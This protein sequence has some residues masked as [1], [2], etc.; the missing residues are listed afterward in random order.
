MRPHGTRSW[1]VIRDQG[2]ATFLFILS[3]HATC[4]RHPHRCR[5]APGFRAVTRQSSPAV[6]QFSFDG[7]GAACMPPRPL[8]HGPGPTVLAVPSLL[9]P[10]LHTGIV[11]ARPN[12]TPAVP[13]RSAGPI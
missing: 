1:T 11:Q 9:H 2:Q 10:V 8:H 5:S 6:N 7:G 13:F 12:S 3:H 4:A